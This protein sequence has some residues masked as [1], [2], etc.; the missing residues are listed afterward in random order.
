VQKYQRRQSFKTH[1]KVRSLAQPVPPLARPC[2][3][4]GPFLLFFQSGG[5]ARAASGT[6]RAA[7]GTAVPSSQ[8]LFLAC[9]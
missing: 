6:A 5:T 8:L 4:V 3:T 7:S 9:F 1:V 2:A